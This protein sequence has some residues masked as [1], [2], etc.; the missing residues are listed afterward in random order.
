MLTLADFRASLAAGEPPV[1]LE[2]PLEALWR[3][4][5]GDWDGAH[6]L[7][8]DD[9]SPDAAW[10]H[11]YLHRVEGDLGNARYWYGQAG[12]SPAAGALESEWE[13][14]AA[15]LLAGHNTLG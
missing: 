10:V 9:G 8:Q 15:A 11:A 12:R 2:P 1:G 14:I 6:R 4:G 3:A 5:T 13:E 7:V